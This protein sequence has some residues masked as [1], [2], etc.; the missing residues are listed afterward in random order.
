MNY[1]PNCN[2][3]GTPTVTIPTTNCINC[4]VAPTIEWACDQGPA[5][6]EAMSFNINGIANINLPS[7][8][9]TYE[10][11]LFSFDNSGFSS[12]TIATNG[13][14]VA[15]TRKVYEHRKTYSILYKI[16]EVGGMRSITGRINVC[17]ADQC[18]TCLGTCD[19]L[20]GDCV[21]GIPQMLEVPCS[22]AISIDITNWIYTTIEFI[23]VNP[24]VTNLVATGGTITGNIGD[25]VAVGE[26]V[27]FQAKIVRDTAQ[28]CIDIILKIADLCGNVCC[29]SCHE[30]DKCTGDCIKTCADLGIE[31]DP[32][33]GGGDPG[34]IIQ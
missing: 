14:V 19:P 17:M 18:L 4:L 25:C 2:N 8:G 9:S 27:S 1:Y 5:P 30:C 13:D 34:I 11:S 7:D 21:Y 10:F 23:N 31:I 26:S 32:G 22:S 28:E 20:T 24:C 33:I 12:V 29:D 6:G 15:Q 16:K 3:C